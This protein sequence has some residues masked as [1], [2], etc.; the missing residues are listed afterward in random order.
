MQS[1]ALSMHFLTEDY[2]AIVIA[3]VLKEILQ[4]WNLNSQ[5]QVSLTTDSGVNV[6]AAVNFLNWTRI[7]CFEH[8]LHLP[9]TKALNNNVRCS[10][11]L[12]VVQKIV[13]AFPLS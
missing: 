2:T 10:R 6:V 9:I 8:N 7:S 3:E 11:E 12:G 13:S 5:K 4:E 1:V